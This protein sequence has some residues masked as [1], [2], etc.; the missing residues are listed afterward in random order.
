MQHLRYGRSDGRLSWGKDI[1]DRLGDR[2]SGVGRM[3]VLLIKPME[4]PKEIDIQPT[5]EEYYKVLD[6]DCITAT[7]PWPELVALV[8]DN[9]GLFTDK[10]FSRYIRELKQPI[11]GSF[12]L[13]GLGKEDFTDLPPELMDKFKKQFWNP[14]LF[15]RTASGLAAIQTSDGTQPE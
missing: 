3:K 7:Y 2:E 6:C 9:N 11:R 8:T 1:A 10:L 4:H 13:C 14:E 5:L 15:V 12:F